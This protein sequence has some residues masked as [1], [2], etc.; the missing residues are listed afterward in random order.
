MP[1]DGVISGQ[2]HGNSNMTKRL[3]S[4]FSTYLSYSRPW[5]NIINNA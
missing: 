2:L 3:T 1:A 4:L 5:F